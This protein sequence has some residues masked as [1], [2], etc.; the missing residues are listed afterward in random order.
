MGIEPTD[1]MISMRSDSFE[2]YGLHQQN[3]HFRLIGSIIDD[4][5]PNVNQQ[6][7]AIISIGQ[8]RNAGR[9]SAIQSAAKRC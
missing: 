5:K 6:S 1:H 3:K 9:I 2:D 4:F 8:P 7:S